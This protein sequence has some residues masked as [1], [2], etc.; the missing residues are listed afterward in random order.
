[1]EKNIFRILLA[2]VFW[3]FFYILLD[4]YVYSTLSVKTLLIAMYGIITGNTG[5]HLWFLYDLMMLYIGIPIFRLV[6]RHA[7]RK[8][9]E[10]LLA[11]WFFASICVSHINEIA[12]SVFGISSL[13]PYNAYPI[14]GYAGYFLLGYYLHRYPLSCKM[15]KMVYFAGI[16]SAVALPALN[17]IFSCYMGVSSVGAFSSPKSIG[18]C[19]M[20]VA[21][22]LFVSEKEKCLGSVRQ[23]SIMCFI[24]KHSFGIYLIH[25][26]WITVIF[27]I[28]Q[29][30]WAVTAVASVLVVPLIAT[31]IGAISLIC[32]MLLSRIPG[33]KR[34]VGG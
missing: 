6:T 5:Y 30:D 2:I 33:I 15:K 12:G 17:I 8:Q 1:M 26:F 28:C 27:H 22:W 23:K 14:A 32:S 24:S 9:M 19:F 4:Q 34:I 29:V 3:G 18:V 10:Y 7:T 13:L 16:L 20:S 25:P 11:I 31:G 21:I